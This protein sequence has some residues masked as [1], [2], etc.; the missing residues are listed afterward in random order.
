G[1]AAPQVGL[2]IRFFV[3]DDGH[4]AKGALANSSIL[5]MDGEVV[6]EEGCLSVPGIYRETRRAERVRISGRDLDGTPVEL[7]GEGLLARI[8]Q[9][10][11]DHV[12]GTIY[13]DRLNEEARRG[14]LAE[15]RER[16]LGDQGSGRR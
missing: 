3:Y 13:I 4:G 11:T 2:S 8:F 14:V 16:E 1:L 9:H 6:E 5:S 15:L 12:N 7:E 10:E